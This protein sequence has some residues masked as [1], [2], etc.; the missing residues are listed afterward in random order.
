LPN[1]DAKRRVLRA[2]LDNYHGTERPV[3]LDKDR[4]WIMHIALLEE[5]LQRPIKLILPVRPIPEILASFETLRQRQ[6]LELTGSEEALGP[7]STIDS[8]AAYFAADGGPIGL[9]Y[10]GM[11]DAI[12][13]GYLNRVLF[14]D[15]NKLM[16]APKMQL[17]RIYDFLEEPNFEHDLK[18]VEQIAKGDSRPHKFVGLHDVRGEF[19]KTS[20][21]AR[22]VLGGDVY[23]KYDRT[24]PWLGWV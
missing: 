10:N 20:R 16:S 22:E 7:S 14:V 18:R 6:P 1:P 23:A 11:K 4:Q 3:V 21:S 9:A 24:E 15:Y 12:T 2:V 5:L 17:A 13:A 8:R 19:A